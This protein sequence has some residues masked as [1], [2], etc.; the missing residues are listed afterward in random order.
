MY[1]KK[2]FITITQE[3]VQEQHGPLFTIDLTAGIPKMLF[4]E[5]ML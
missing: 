5:Y 4:L 2:Y 1:L 3:H